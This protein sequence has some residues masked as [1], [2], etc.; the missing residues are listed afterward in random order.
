MKFNY[1]K[2]STIKLI[3][4]AI[5]LFVFGILSWHYQAWDSAKYCFGLLGLDLIALLTFRFFA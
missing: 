2:Y 3:I 1:H 4:L 5:I